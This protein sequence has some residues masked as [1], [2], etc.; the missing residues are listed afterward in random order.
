MDVVSTD[1]RIKTVL[2]RLEMII[3]NEN[4]R[5]GRDSG[6]DLKVS[7]AHKSRCLYELTTLFR[8]PDVKETSAPYLGQLQG[9]K[10]KLKLNAQRVEAHLEA[11]RAVAD[12]LK[13]AVKDMDADGTYS[14]HQFRF[15]TS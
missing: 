13:N 4:D 9:L 10:K 15:G 2:S 3:D 12:I 11:V 6:F 8:G 1:Y 14:E 7:N 5:I